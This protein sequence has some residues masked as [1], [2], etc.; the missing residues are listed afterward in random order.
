M[1]GSKAE[2]Q[3]KPGFDK[4]EYHEMLRVCAQIVGT[5]A[6]DARKDLKPLYHTLAYRSDVTALD[7][8][9][10]LWVHKN[11][12]SAVISLRGTTLKSESWLENFFAAMVPARGK[13]YLSAADT[14]RSNAGWLIGMAAQARTIVPKIDSCYK[15]GI[16][17]FVIMG[18]SQGGAIAYLLRSHLH[19]LQ[20]KGKL[21]KD[22]QFKTYCSAAPKPGNLYY[23]YDYED[24]T[25]NG[26]GFTVLNSE[27][28]VPETPLSL[29]TVNDY[30]DVNPFKGAGEMLAKQPFP[31]NIVL[32]L[33]YNSMRRPAARL[34]RRYK[35]YL[36]DQAYKMIKGHMA[37]LEKPEFYSSSNY[38]RAGT[39]II[40]KADKAY[41]E[42][43]H[44]STNVFVHHFFDPYL[45]LLK[46][47]N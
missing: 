44:D 38:M 29:Q 30:N 33:V 9:W 4:E 13:L 22:I 41:H 5:P 11:G 1:I 40:L 17:D 46:Q 19:Y 14:F 10:D 36:G 7:N 20:Q 21:P 18:H 6:T 39:P 43:F 25:R 34:Q 37:E 26:W 3:L 12:K 2:A 15:N 28:W 32:K 45:Y 27:D 42:K 24:I 35:K 8:R 47:Y 16:K 31:K 23:A